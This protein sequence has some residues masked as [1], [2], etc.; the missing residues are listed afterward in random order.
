M[1]AALH[2]C[3]PSI[4]SI[5]CGSED[6]TVETKH[7]DRLGRISRSCLNCFVLQVLWLSNHNA[8]TSKP[9]LRVSVYIP[10]REG[11]QPQGLPEIS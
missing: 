4:C 10:L 1:Y 3:C 5:Y 11:N 8:D 2:E 6:N 9:V 7:V